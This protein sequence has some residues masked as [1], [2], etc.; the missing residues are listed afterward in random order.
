M[1][2]HDLAGRILEVASDLLRAVVEKDQIGIRMLIL[3]NPGGMFVL[4]RRLVLGHEPAMT[5]SS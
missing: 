2:W 3:S 5:G 4:L 1:G